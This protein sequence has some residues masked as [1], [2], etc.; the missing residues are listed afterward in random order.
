MGVQ[1][2]WD[3]AAYINSQERPQDPRYTGD[4]HETRELYL[5]TFHQYTYYGLEKEGR[6]LGDHM[7]LGRKDFLKPD[8]LRAR[9]FE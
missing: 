4:V 1:E 8:V 9:T 5:K 3:L 6:L 7:D 2:S